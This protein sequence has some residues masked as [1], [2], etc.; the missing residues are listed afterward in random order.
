MKELLTWVSRWSYWGPPRHSISLPSMGQLFREI[1]ID[2]SNVY[3]HLEGIDP[4]SPAFLNIRWLS[5]SR[6]LSLKF[7]HKAPTSLNL[8][9][10]KKYIVGKSQLQTL[11]IISNKFSRNATFWDTNIQQDERIPAIKHLVL[12]NYNWWHYPPYGVHFWSWTNVTHLGLKG[13]CINN[14][15]HAVPARYLVQLQDMLLEDRCPRLHHEATEGMHNLL[16]QIRSLEN[17]SIKYKLAHPIAAIVGHG[18][19]LRYLHIFDYERPSSPQWNR[20]SMAKLR[21]IRDT[22]LCI[23]ELSLDIDFS[24]R[25]L[26][27]ML[28]GFRNLRRLTITTRTQH[29][30]SFKADEEA[31]ELV[32]GAVRTWLKCL[33][34]NKQGTKY[35]KV[36]LIM[37]VEL[38]KTSEDDSPTKLVPINYSYVDGNDINGALVNRI[39]PTS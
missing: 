2:L 24:S 22:S 13:I 32:H 10:V 31:Y 34:S 11:H 9:L 17:L 7:E 29:R 4:S 39:R 37:Y 14:F 23:M 18:P 21:A 33:V 38:E 25:C 15:L 35:E 28:A 20:L 19:S 27:T 5:P 30:V 26:V 1:A 6:I 36:D 12:E 3:F 16:N 8:D